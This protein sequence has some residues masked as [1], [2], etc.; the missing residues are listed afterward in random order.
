MSDATRIGEETT[1]DVATRVVLSYPADLS[2]HALTRIGQ[3][4][5]RTYLRRVHDTAA[6]GDAWAEFTDVGCCGSQTAVPLRVEAVKDGSRI[7]PETE[8]AYRERDAEGLN[9]G[10]SAQHDE[11]E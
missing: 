3:D 10:W 5:Y 9:R 6:V 8:V 4:Y 7:G 2:E 1:E 11:P